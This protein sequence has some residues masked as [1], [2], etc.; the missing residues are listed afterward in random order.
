MLEVDMEVVVEELPR[1]V[2]HVW[3]IDEERGEL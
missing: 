1:W 2:V 3:V